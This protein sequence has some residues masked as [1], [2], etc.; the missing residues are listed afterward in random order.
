MATDR[1]PDNI[2]ANPLETIVDFK[3]DDQVVGV[4]ADMIN[5]SVP[6]YSTIIKSLGILASQ[7]AQPDSR[8]YDLG[9]SLGA[10]TL[11]MRQ[12]V[13]QPNCR[14][15]AIDNSEAMINR[16]REHLQVANCDEQVELICGDILDQNIDEASVVIMNF[17]L[18][19][20]APE[21][22]EQLL[23]RIYQGLK[24][25]GVL[26]LS[27]KIR[28]DDAESDQQLID[29]YH[30]FKRANGYSELEISQKR[31]ALEKVLIPET[32]EAHQQRLQGVGFKQIQPWFQCFNF[33]SLAAIK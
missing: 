2:Y 30:Q 5:R 29:W 19:F 10:A 3:F 25:G 1:T 16:C 6:G 7:Y 11:S 33:I 4:F 31:S 28:I 26:L 18:Q 21:L 15:I 13:S 23:Q 14:F 12:Q 17:T 8:C 32:L 24:P 9:C 20:I 22:R 27:E